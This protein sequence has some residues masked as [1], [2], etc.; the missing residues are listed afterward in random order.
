MFDRET[1][2]VLGECAGL[3]LPSWAAVAAALSLS[4]A[5][6]LCSVQHYKQLLISL[7]PNGRKSAG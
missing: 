4:L 3:Q 5:L 6:V 1:A 7:T 2:S